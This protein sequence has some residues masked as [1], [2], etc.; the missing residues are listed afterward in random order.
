MASDDLTDLFSHLAGL[1]RADPQAA[2]RFAETNDDTA[3]RELILHRVAQLWA[4]RD[5]SAALAWAAGLTNPTERDALFT[6]VCL[7][8]AERDP[9]EAVRLSGEHPHGGLEALAQ[10]WAE[11]D[12]TAARDWA[13]SR[14]DGTQRDRLVARLAFQQA[15]DSPLEAATL[16]ANEIPEGDIQAEAVMAVLHQWTNRDPAAAAEWVALF[17]EGELRTRATAEMQ[18]IRSERDR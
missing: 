17:S 13:L 11:R 4:E 12:F 5:A 18:G 14:P 16:A 2:A 9:A 10:R 1:A 6:D 8:L 15:Q 7:Q 3:T